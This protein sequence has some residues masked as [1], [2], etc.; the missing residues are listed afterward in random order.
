MVEPLAC[1]TGAGTANG[2]GVGKDNEDNVYR[3]V[4]CTEQHIGQSV[5]EEQRRQAGCIAG[6]MPP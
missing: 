3:I 2:F 6:R 4:F 1:I 5:G